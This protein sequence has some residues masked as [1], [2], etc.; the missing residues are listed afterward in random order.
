MMLMRIFI[1]LGTVIL[2]VN[3]CLPLPSI[4]KENVSK[5]PENLDYLIAYYPF[6]GTADDHGENGYDGLAVGDPT[7]ID[8]TPDGSGSAIRLNGFK[9]QYINIPYSFLNDLKE[10]SVSFWIKDFSIG[11]VF[12]SISSDYVRSDYPRLLITDGQKFR[13]YTGYD[14]YDSTA[15]F[16]YD[17]TSIMSSVWHHIVLVVCSDASSGNRSL[18]KKLYVDGNLVDSAAADWWEG[19]STK[20]NIGGN[21]NGSYSVSLTAKFD[22]FRFYGCGLKGNDVLYLFNNCL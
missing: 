16:V 9:G 14:N 1:Y 8:D 19:A 11:M 2:L 7:Y 4:D 20:I 13:F 18:V 17:C 3:G 21:R 6:E 10:Y 22:N 15:P 12:S 5:D